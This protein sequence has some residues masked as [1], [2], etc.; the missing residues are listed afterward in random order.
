MSLGFANAT[1]AVVA[2]AF[3]AGTATASFAQKT[4]GNQDVDPVYFDLGMDVTLL[5]KDSA[6]AK[7]F[8]AEQISITQHV[9]AATCDNYLKHPVAAEMPETIQFCKALFEGGVPV[10]K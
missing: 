4:T 5:P 6:G 3:V 7:K 2:I 10:V 8:F 9:L 1:A